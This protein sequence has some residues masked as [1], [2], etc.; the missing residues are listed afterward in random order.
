MKECTL[1][2]SKQSQ[3]T[4]NRKEWTEAVILFFHVLS[5]S[6]VDF[7]HHPSKGDDQRPKGIRW[8]GWWRVLWR[9]IESRCFW[10]RS[11]VLSA[12]GR[13]ERVL[14]VREVEIDA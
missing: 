1:A 8:G 9:A 7:F 13:L 11:S 5:S 10:I 4:F 12:S 6:E 2:L 14:A 3:S